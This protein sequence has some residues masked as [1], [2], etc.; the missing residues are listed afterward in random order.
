[1]HVHAHSVLGLLSKSRG[2]VLRVVSVL[3]TLFCVHAFCWYH[4]EGTSTNL[5]YFSNISITSSAWVSTCLNGSTTKKLWNCVTIL[6]KPTINFYVLIIRYKGDVTTVG[7]KKQGRKVLLGEL[8]S[9]AAWMTWWK[10]MFKECIVLLQKL[11]C[12]WLVLRVSSRLT[13]S[14]VPTWPNIKC[15]AI[16]Q[17][18]CLK[19]P[20]KNLKAK[21]L[22]QVQVLPN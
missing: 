16:Q 15:K 6:N 18:V 22:K 19:C 12:I 17:R 13:M 7:M 9:R 5:C 8:R 21:F 20:M 11:W 3:H 4:Q 1:M 10:S 14:F 2:L